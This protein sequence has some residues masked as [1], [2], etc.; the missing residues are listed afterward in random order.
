MGSGDDV[1]L[2]AAK[3]HGI[4]IEMKQRLASAERDLNQPHLVLHVTSD[5][6]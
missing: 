2:V 6:D 1:A 4:N 5:L 3:P